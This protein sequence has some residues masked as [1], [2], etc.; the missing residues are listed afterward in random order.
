MMLNELHKS[1]ITQFENSDS[2]QRMNGAETDQKKLLI[3]KVLK[4]IS[5]QYAEIQV[6]NTKWQGRLET[7]LTTNTYY[8]FSYEKKADEPQ[9]RLQVVE[10]FDKNP[11]TV[12]DAAVKLLDGLSLKSTKE[13]VF[14]VGALL[15][16]Q[17]PIKENDVKAA[18]KWLENLP[19]SQ[20]QKGM[21]AVIFALKRQLPVHPGVLDS[22]LAVKDPVSISSQIGKLYEAISH[23][24]QHT[25]GLEKLKSALLPILNVE[26]EIQA[27][28]LLQILSE[29]ARPAGKETQPTSLLQTAQG[30]E[31]AN[32]QD[33]KMTHPKLHEPA[34][35][36]E[37]LT[38]LT[39]LAEQKGTTLV[40]EAITWMKSL[41]SH[42]PMTFAKLTESETELLQHIIKESAP[43]LTNK[44]DVLTALFK[45]KNLLGVK[46]ELSFVKAL[47][48]GGV[49]K[50]QSLQSLKLVLNEMRHSQDLSPSVKQEVNEVFNRLNGQL[51]LQHDQSTQSQLFLSYPLFSKHSVQDLT[52]FFNGQKKEDGKIDPSQC[53]LMFY[54]QLDALKETV[55]DCF[56]QQKVMTVTIETG[57]DL[58]GLIDPLFPSLKEKLKELGY[59]L[60]SV[61]AKKREHLQIP[62]CME[63]QFEQMTQYTLDVKI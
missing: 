32:E 14:L 31:L 13:A 33:N 45:M 8:W 23:E 51:F 61:T 42:K 35:A 40:E 59:S 24:P 46:D 54:L 28:N 30:G 52:V 12:Q 58:Q 37:I 15:K 26:T 55:V 53:R 16:E 3:G 10:A 49:T 27:E 11:K 41:Q 34:M 17:Q 25:A 56:I 9:G 7:P 44:T 22:I 63:S 47:E 21:D 60:S 36:K 48:S 57:F 19:K 29:K 62:S 4:F 5:E 38:K 1:L 39:T 2:L 20:I 18:I 43:S 6:G 50:E